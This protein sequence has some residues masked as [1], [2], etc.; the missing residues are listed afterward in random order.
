MGCALHPL[1]CTAVQWTRDAC[2]LVMTGILF[3][4]AAGWLWSAGY[5][6]SPALSMHASAP[7]KS[8]QK[9]N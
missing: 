5:T 4:D 6:E 2:T 7:A 9:K 1:W 3:S 8:A